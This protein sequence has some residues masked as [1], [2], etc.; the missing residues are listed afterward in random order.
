[1]NAAGTRALAPVAPAR[2][3]PF[4][5]LAAMAVAMGCA[6][7]SPHPPDSSQPPRQPEL[8]RLPEE[9]DPETLGDDLLLVDPVDVAPASSPESL[10]S[11]SRPAMSVG[12][13]S[14]VSVRPAAGNS[15][16]GTPLIGNQ[17]RPEPAAAAPQRLV[18]AFGW[19]VLL[20]KVHTYEEAEQVRQQAMAVLGRTDID[21]GFKAP[22]YNVEQG[23][24]QAE[25]E[26]QQALERVKERF[27]NA[28]KVRGQILIPAEE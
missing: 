18:K 5:L 23:H 12:Q 3:W 9:F 27:P 20:D 2:A 8:R 4:P 25:T 19:R 7:R 21:I 22:W 6:G 15:G 16:L 26:A 14:S 17:T 10:P 28:L 11:A 13:P 24:Y 1:M